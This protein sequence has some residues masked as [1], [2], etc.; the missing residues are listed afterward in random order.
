[1]LWAAIVNILCCCVLFVYETI[2]LLFG[3]KVGAGAMEITYRI[4]WHQAAWETLRDTLHNEWE[5]EPKRL[6]HAVRGATGETLFKASWQ[7]DMW[8][9]WPCEQQVKNAIN[10][11]LAKQLQPQ[12]QLNAEE[13]MLIRHLTQIDLFFALLRSS[14]AC[15]NNVEQFRQRDMNYASCRVSTTFMAD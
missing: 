6:G 10:K 2:S 8:R 14:P 11:S 9:L 13:N 15:I 4:C 12:K 1:M 3:V 7:L 5:N